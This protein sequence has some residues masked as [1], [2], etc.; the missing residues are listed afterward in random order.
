MEIYKIPSLFGNM[1]TLQR[2]DL[3]NNKLN[4][5]ISSFFQNSSWCNRDIFKILYLSFNRLIGMLPESIGLL[6]EL[7]ELS[8]AVN[9]LEGDV[10]KSHLCNFSKLKLLYL[11]ENLLSLKLVLSWFPPFQ[12][13]ILGLT[14][15]K[16]GHTFPSWLKT[17]SSLYE[18]DISDNRI[19]DSVPDWFWNNLQYMRYLNMS[20]NYLIGVIPNISWCNS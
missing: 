7:E 15:C 12:L 6:S 10:T 16:L 5:E 14:S 18:L 11:S 3:S 17:Q 8:L 9:S 4:G 1:C 2:L 19:N 20:Y 13:E